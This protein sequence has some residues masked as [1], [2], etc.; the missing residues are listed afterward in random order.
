MAQEEL[1]GPPAWQLTAAGRS[2][3]LPPE[4][5]AEGRNKMVRHVMQEK[6]K[7]Q[8]IPVFLACVDAELRFGVVVSKSEGP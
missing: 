4:S 8:T 2:M 1:L 3:M 7:I 5:R 6:S